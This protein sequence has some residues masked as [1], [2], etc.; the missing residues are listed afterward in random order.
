MIECKA[1]QV[2]DDLTVPRPCIDVGTVRFH[3]E[4]S[5]ELTL[6][7]SLEEYVKASM[8]IEMLKALGLARGLEDPVFDMSVG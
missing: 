4:W 3:V 1:I 5:Q 7:H 8:L 2:R 6:D